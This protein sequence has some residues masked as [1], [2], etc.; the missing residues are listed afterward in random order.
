MLPPNQLLVKCSP[1]VSLA[2]VT[3]VS[4]PTT[5]QEPRI[6]TLLER[7]YT[8]ERAEAVGRRINSYLKDS[9]SQGVSHFTPSG[10]RWTPSL[11]TLMPST[12]AL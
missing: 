1:N 3:H 2:W 7:M 6:A 8:Q 10:V 9:S 11:R 12:L 4:E 5:L